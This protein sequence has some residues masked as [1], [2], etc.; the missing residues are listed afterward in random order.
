MFLEL[1]ANRCSKSMSVI[2][3][4]FRGGNKNDFPTPKDH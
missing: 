3:H 4:V 2:S 1:Q